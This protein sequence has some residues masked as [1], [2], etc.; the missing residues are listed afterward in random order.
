M[1]CDN[2]AYKVIGTIIVIIA[3]I[4]KFSY[5]DNKLNVSPKNVIFVLIVVP[6]LLLLSNFRRK[7]NNKRTEK[8]IDC[9]VIFLCLTVSTIG[10]ML[11]NIEKYNV[12]YLELI[13]FPLA[14][15]IVYLTSKWRKASI[16]NRTE[17]M[18]NIIKNGEIPP[19]NNLSHLDL[20]FVKNALKSKQKE[21]GLFN[22]DVYKNPEELQNSETEFEPKSNIKSSSYPYSNVIHCCPKCASTSYVKYNVN[23]ESSQSDNSNSEDLDEYYTCLNCGHKFKLVEK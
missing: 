11:I 8:I 21:N 15:L 13:C 18:M 23:F 7:I 12:M 9:I 4:L 16:N 3:L 20:L 14:I 22:K 17:E 6:S 1:Y 10:I 5:E 2:K 19:D